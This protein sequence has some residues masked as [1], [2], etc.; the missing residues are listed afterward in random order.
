LDIGVEATRFHLFEFQA[1][2]FGTTT[3]EEAPFHFLRGEDGWKRV[4]GRSEV[5]EEFVR[6]VVEY[7]RDKESGRDPGEAGAL[8]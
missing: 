5:E 3:I 7:L 2:H 8:P 1:V 4:D 6:S